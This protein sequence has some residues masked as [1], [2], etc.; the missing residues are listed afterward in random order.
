MWSP[1]A[2][3]LL[4]QFCARPGPRATRTVP[5]RRK[6]GARLAVAGAFDG[7]PDGP[8]LRIGRS[9]EL[10]DNSN[11]PPDSLMYGSMY[12]AHRVREV[13]GGAFR[14]SGPSF[15]R[16]YASIPKREPHPLPAEDPVTRVTLR[17]PC[18]RS[19][20]TN[21][22]L[23]FRAVSWHSRNQSTISSDESCFLR[24]AGFSL[25]VGLS[26]SANRFRPDGPG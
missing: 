14:T 1:S 25:S 3:F 17:E 15:D 6:L 2:V 24:I 22:W 5:H 8:H 11:G 10:W 20:F 13:W 26:R 7:L 23:R 12:A 9:A 18:C 4:A 21:H 19:T 16:D